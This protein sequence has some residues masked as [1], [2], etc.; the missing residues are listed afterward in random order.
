MI[1]NETIVFLH[2]SNNIYKDRMLNAIQEI[3]IRGA[4]IVVITNAHLD[5]EEDIN[6]I[7]LEIDDE[8]FFSLLSVMIYQYIALELAVSLGN[9]PDMPRNLAKVITVDG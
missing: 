4:H 9:T 2:I 7:E 6:M 3:K 8:I 1:D 5:T